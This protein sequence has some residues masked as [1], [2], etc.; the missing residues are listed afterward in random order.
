M[1][2]FDAKTGVKADE[3]ADIRE[4]VRLEWVEAFKKDGQPNLDTDPETPAG[5]LIDSET[6]HIAEKDNEFL[7]LANQFNPLSAE[8]VWQE[9]L[10]KI[11]FLKRKH[12][13]HSVALCTITGLKGTVVP[14]GA[15]IRSSAD[16]SLWINAHEVTIPAAGSIQ[17]DFVSEEYGPIT[18]GANTLTNIVTIVP[19]WDAVNNDTAATIG[20]YTETQME[21]ESRRYESV[22]ANSHGSLASIYGAL[23]NLDDVI[24]CVILENIEN[25]PVVQYG[26]TIPPH[27]IFVSIVGGDETKISEIIYKKKDAGC[28]TAGNTIISYQ[29]T[30]LPGSPV[31]RYKIERPNSLAVGIKIDIKATS[32]TP[33]DADNLI[34]SALIA[35]FSGNGPHGNLRV[36]IAQTVFASRFY[37]AVI[38][39]GGNGLEKI[40]ICAP[41]SSLNWGDSITINAD[42]SPV[43]DAANIIINWI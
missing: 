43:L 33:P 15:Q 6:Q 26:V 32:T 16:N 11:Y 8:G 35:D 10:G 25:D 27:S 34:K 7:F 21:F 24:D 4:A 17:T 12:K 30:E 37:C 23:C 5:Q 18:A 20:R 13:Q 14:V 3:I 41:Y 29:D 31:F 39:T 9:A 36:G 42:Y 2:T 40:E 38:N 28:G 1:L 19:G 22:A